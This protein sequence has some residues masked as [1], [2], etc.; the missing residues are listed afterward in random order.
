MV[1]A[2]D[3][4]NSSNFGTGTVGCLLDNTGFGFGNFLDAIQN[5]LVSIVIALGVAYAIVSL[6]GSIGNNLKVR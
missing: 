1:A 2:Y 5:P 6:I 4:L 3:C